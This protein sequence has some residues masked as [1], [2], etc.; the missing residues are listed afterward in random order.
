MNKQQQRPDA[1]VLILSQVESMTRLENGNNK[2]IISGQEWMVDSNPKTAS[3]MYDIEGD[4]W[5]LAVTML[6]AEVHNVESYQG[7]TLVTYGD[8]LSPSFS[9]FFEGKEVEGGTLDMQT[10]DLKQFVNSKQSEYKGE[11]P[12]EAD[13]ALIGIT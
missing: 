2:F 1:I 10:V 9:I 11:I 3:E 5:T 13:L 8:D 4:V 12:V 7:Y 6:L